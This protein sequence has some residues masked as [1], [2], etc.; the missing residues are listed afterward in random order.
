MCF[1]GCRRSVP[2][3][4][5]RS[6]R[7]R[8]ARGAGC[9]A[10]GGAGGARG[11]AVRA[12][13]GDGR[14]AADPQSLAG[15]SLEILESERA[16]F[17]PVINA[18][19]VLLHTG[20]G[21]APLAEEAIEA[22]AA[23]ARGYCNL[24][25]DL[26]DGEPRPAHFGDR[27]P[28]LRADRGRGRD[29][30]EQQRRGDRAGASGPGGRARGDRLA[31]RARRDRRQLPA[32]RDLRGLGGEAARSRHDQQDAAVGLRARDRPGDG[33]DPAGPSQQLPDRRLHRGC[34]SFGELVRLA[35]DRA[36]G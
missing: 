23:V 9:G 34:R 33:R 11:S 2:C 20:L 7:R 28:A 8:C 1:A 18:T 4:S 31:R 32:P 15:R 10:S 3:S 19:G 36:S 25:L 17:R 14:I 24:E 12:A 6:W 13:R 21:R 16:T 35:H 27:A 22:V 26:E 5:T 29:G 30:R